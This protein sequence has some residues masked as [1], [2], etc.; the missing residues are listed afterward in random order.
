MLRK[1]SFTKDS[2]RVSVDA[3]LLSDDFYTYKY[4]N[5]EFIFDSEGK[6]HFKVLSHKKLT[7]EVRCKECQKIKSV[8]QIPV[9]LLNN[10]RNPSE[11]ISLIQKKIC[12]IPTSVIGID[13]FSDKKELNNNFLKVTFTRNGKKISKD[14]RDLSDGFFE[15]TYMGYKFIFDSNKKAHY[16]K[17]YPYSVG[18]K[19]R[20]SKCKKIV[21]VT[22]MIVQVLNSHRKPSKYVE[23]LQMKSCHMLTEINGY[24]GDIATF[25]KWYY[26]ERNGN[27]FGQK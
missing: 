9:Y 13:L 5:K 14:A 6:Q 18:K 12:H 15:Y 17:L 10:R 4:Q 2:K 27:R 21:G 19:S 1:I 24:F 3:K 26:E 7:K 23:L 11:K 22:S 20:C 16:K 25:E 8:T